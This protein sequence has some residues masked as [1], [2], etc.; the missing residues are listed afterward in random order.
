M[1]YWAN[2]AKNGYVIANACIKK[3][4]LVWGKNKWN[5]SFE[6]AKPNRNW[7]FFSIPVNDMFHSGP[8]GPN[9]RL[10]EKL[11]QRPKQE[12]GRQLGTF[13]RRRILAY[14]LPHIQGVPGDIHHQPLLGQGVESQGVLLLV[15]LLAATTQERWA[16]GILHNCID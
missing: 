8:W 13:I 3:M 10:N 7:Q 4:Q 2:F 9:L 6:K 12:H 5:C 11:F 15:T 16:F 1:V 14:T